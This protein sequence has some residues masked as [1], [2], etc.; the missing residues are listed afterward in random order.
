MD[1][2]PQAISTFPM[3]MQCEIHLSKGTPDGY[4][5]LSTANGH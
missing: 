4:L 1:D 3:E 2:H 5:E